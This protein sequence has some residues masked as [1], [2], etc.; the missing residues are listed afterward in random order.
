MKRSKFT[1]SQ[2]AQE[3]A[4]DWVIDYNEFRPHDSLGDKTPMEFMPRI[5]KP[6]ISSSDL[7]T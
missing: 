7:S 6:G 4:D 5:F 1:D 2:M 3:A